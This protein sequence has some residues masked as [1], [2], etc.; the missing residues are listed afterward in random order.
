MKESPCLHA[1]FTPDGVLV[2]RYVDGSR[3]ATALYPTIEDAVAGIEITLKMAERDYL[4]PAMT[5]TEVEME[6]FARAVE[7]RIDQM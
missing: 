4:F 6:L 2:E 5:D 7:T 1:Q 3:V